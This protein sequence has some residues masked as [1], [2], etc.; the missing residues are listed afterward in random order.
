MKA[1]K[2]RAK[3]AAAGEIS[4]AEFP[5][6]RQFLRGYLHEDWREENDTAADA[7]RQFLED[8]DATERQQ[9]ASEWQ[10]FRERTKGQ[11]LDVINRVLDQTFGAGWRVQD[12]RELDAV[13]LA[14]RH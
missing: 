4:A 12:P 11:S 7:A 1:K 10:N 8:A 6:L 3:P 5:A 14:F 13:S 2:P 9:V